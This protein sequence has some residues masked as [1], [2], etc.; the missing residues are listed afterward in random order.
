MKINLQDIDQTQFMVHEHIVNGEVLTLVQPQHIG[1]NWTKDNT[2]FRS[3]LWNSEGELVSAGFPKFV[4]WGEKPEVFPLPNSLEGA[5]VVDKLDGSLLIVSKYKGNYI[6]RTR[7]TSDASTMENGHEL[8]LFKET[9]LPKVIAFM[10]SRD[11]WETSVLFEWTSPENKIVINYGDVPTWSLVGVV[12]HQSYQLLDQESLDYYANQFG[13]TRP[14]SYKFS[15]IENLIED[16]AK[17]TG[18]EGV[19]V[20]SNND[21]MIHKVK[22]EW[23]LIRHRMKS[24]LNSMEKLMDFWFN[25]GAPGYAEFQD[26]IQKFDFEIWDDVRG[27][28]SKIIDGK[29]EVDKIVAHMIDFTNALKLSCHTRKEQAGKVISAYGDT[30]RAAFLFRLLDGK[31]LGNEELKKLMFQVLK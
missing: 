7:G 18:R 29:K 25:N 2:H 14:A 19:C 10:P 3:S 20:Y 11:T 16:I 13:F 23:Y 1:C 31:T 4:N 6:L 28:A 15:S 8:E 5:T 24:E 17:L 22:S 30:N 9:V 21:Q 27:N 12:S 26:V